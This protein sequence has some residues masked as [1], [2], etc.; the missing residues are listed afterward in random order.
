M[1]NR[2]RTIKIALAGNANVGKSTIFNQITGLAQHVGNWPGKTVEK[3]EGIV[4]YGSYIVEVL[5]LP[6]TYSLSA[7]SEEEVIAREY[8]AT[9]KPDIILNVIDASSLERNLYLTIQILELEAPVVVALNLIDIATK[10]GLNIAIN[11]LSEILGVPVIP[12]IAIS[13]QGVD[14]ALSIAVKAAL[15]EIKLNP[16]KIRY[17]KEVEDSIEK[18]RHII[19]EKASFLC[20]TYPP[21]WLAVKLLERDNEVISKFNSISEGREIL[22]LAESLACRLEEVHGEPSHIIIAAERYALASKIAN[23]VLKVKT[24]P[25]SSLIE[26]L[27][28][29]TTHK[30]WGYLI[31]IL[32]LT[33][34][35]SLIFFIGGY[36]SGL[37]EELLY[38]LIN[39]LPA[40]RFRVIRGFIDGFVAGLVLVI[41]YV[42][43][44][45]ILLYIMED[46]GYLPRAAF[47]VD[48]LMHK[49]GL[50]GKALIPLLL[51]YGCNVPACIGCRIMESWREK[52]ILGFLI[53]IVPCAARTI[54]ILNLVGNYIGVHVALILY[55]MNL[56]LVFAIGKLANLWLTGEAIGLIMEMP[57][58]RIPS[59]KIILLKTYIRIKEFLYIAFPLLIIGSGFVNYLEETGLLNVIE[60]EFEPIVSSLLGLPTVTVVP[61]I[62]GILRKELVIAMLAEASGTM[63]FSLV[64]TPRQMIVFTIFT[65]LYIPCIATLAALVKEYG[66]KK[67]LVIT[68]ANIILAITVS[69]IINIS[70]LV[71]NYS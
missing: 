64:L 13:G 55:I 9:E 59:I 45:Y 6:G 31:L 20:R 10:R 58:F 42:V 18:L 19:T 69:L 12:M 60:K 61:L 7:Y 70:L 32:V 17:G 5:D 21:R 33:S 2:S 15:G 65:M 26:N 35:F 57:P 37:L 27:S 52:L 25:T 51:G 28:L 39:E 48:G 11:R 68:A 43:P 34:M 47:L 46:S 41:P 63:N 30:I 38:V 36:L 66:V 62:L 24:P 53:T 16:L 23:E 49:I 71:Y 44:F 54:I 1:T 8:I 22:L 3:A 40:L 29:I 50:H 14:E 4:K 67:T 56:A